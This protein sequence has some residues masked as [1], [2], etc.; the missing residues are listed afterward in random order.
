[1]KG[2]KKL[3]VFAALL[4]CLAIAGKMMLNSHPVS[5]TSPNSTSVQF[6]PNVPF[7]ETESPGF[8]FPTAT[9]TVPA[10][11]HL[12]IETLS[13]QVDVTPSGSQVGA[14]VTYTSAGNNVTLSVPLTFAYTSPSNHYD[15]YVATQAVR[16]YADPGT[17]VNF[18]AINPPGSTGSTGTPFLSVSGYLN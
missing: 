8:G 7:A 6:V 16:L 13:L 10:K 18:T 5:A 12:I 17:S 1:M 9:V 3:L 2:F 4:A 15:T 14:V 11:Q